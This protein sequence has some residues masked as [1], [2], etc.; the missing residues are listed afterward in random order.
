MIRDRH[1]LPLHQ[2]THVVFG[3]E[4]AE[5]ESSQPRVRDL[6]GDLS[7]EP[8]QHQAAVVARLLREQRR[9]AVP[10]EPELRPHPLARQ[11]S[12]SKADEAHEIAGRRAEDVR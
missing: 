10:V 3:V 6:R 5:A 12:V 9:D 11:R 2:P 1:H 8:R 7:F 4:A